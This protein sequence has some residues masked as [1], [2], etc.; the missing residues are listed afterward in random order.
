MGEYGFDLKR[1]VSKLESVAQ[2]L[3][4]ERR[5]KRYLLRSFD[6][7]TYKWW[8]FIIHLGRGVGG[9]M[10]TTGWGQTIGILTATRESFIV[11]CRKIFELRNRVMKS[12]VNSSART[13]GAFLALCLSPHTASCTAFGTSSH[14]SVWFSQNELEYHYKFDLSIFD[15]LMQNHPLHK[16]LF[17]GNRCF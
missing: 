3:Q 16:H 4:C 8:L 14:L 5:M 17:L 12:K 11:S 1:E 6:G 9:R 7:T 13:L 10:W 15:K 2:T